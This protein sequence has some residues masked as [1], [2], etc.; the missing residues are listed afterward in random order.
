MSLKK[1]QQIRRYL[2]IAA[3]DIPQTTEE[4]KK[5]S[6][7]KVDRMMNQL[8][9]ASPALRLSSSNI[10]IDDAMI[11]CTGC[12]QDTY[13]IPSKPIELGFKFH[14]VANHGYIW[15]FHRTSN[16]TSPDPVPVIQ[17]LTAT[18]EIVI[19]LASKLTSEGPGTYP[20]ITSI[21]AY[22]YLP[23]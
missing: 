11:Q 14:C 20:L 16:Q 23:C 6:H 8:R 21:P 15:D 5:L 22:L 4:G 13:K 10:T 7:G 18:A 3:L 1:F 9:S 19:F 12:S 17:N 2:H